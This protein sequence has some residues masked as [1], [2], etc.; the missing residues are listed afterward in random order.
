MCI[1]LVQDVLTVN[2]A[3]STERQYKSPSLTVIPVGSV[4]AEW[5]PSS[6]NFE[7]SMLSPMQSPE[8]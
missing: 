2:W 4:S 6:R 8:S 7:G 5:G 1:A 3:Y